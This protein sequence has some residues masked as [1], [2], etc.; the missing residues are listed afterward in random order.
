MAA[1]TGG[2]H[3]Y[4]YMDGR[5]PL[6]S[7]WNYHNIVNWLYPKYKSLKKKKKQSASKPQRWAELTWT[8][9]TRYTEV[10]LEPGVMTE[11]QE[12]PEIKKLRPCFVMRFAELQYY[13]QLKNLSY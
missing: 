4:M 10:V 5:A 3:G 9:Y 12:G 8:C 6:L 1:W 7:P 11:T 13:K 2:E